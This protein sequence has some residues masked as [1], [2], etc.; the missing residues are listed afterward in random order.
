MLGFI[1]NF[2]PFGRKE[3]ARI[4]F[5]RYV[6]SMP[7]LQNAIDLAPGWSSAFP[8][9]CGVVAGDLETYRDARIQW[10]IECAGGSLADRDVIELG[11]REAGHTA[12]L[13]A[14][15]AR[16][17]AI[18]ADQLAFMRCLLAKEVMG[19]TQARFWHGDYVKW[20]EN[21]D[22]SYDLLIAAD[23]LRNTID[24]LRLIDL[25]AQRANAVFLVTQ[26]VTEAATSPAEVRD[27]HDTPIRLYRRGYPNPA[28][29]PAFSGGTHI[30]RRWLHRDDLLAA[31]QAVDFNTIKIN[32]DESDQI[33]GPTFSIFASK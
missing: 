2:R 20:L 11:P 17:D 15:G 14:A 24:P 18:E 23:V 5:D 10:A 29:R 7:S 1:K 27:F 30:E 13:E 33:S 28:T 16:V 22:K 25:I 4:T 19:L 26:L 8:P 31:L 12:M 9:H 21:T 3:D 32:Q 6:D